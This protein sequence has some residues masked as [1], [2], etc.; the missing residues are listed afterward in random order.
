M[1]LLQVYARYAA[2]VHLLEELLHVGAALVPNPCLGEQAARCP[3]LEDADAEVYVLAEAHGGKTAQAPVEVGTYAHVEGARIELVQ[4]LLA[5]AYASCGEEGGH[6]V[7]DGLLHGRETLVCAVGTSESV[8]WFARKFVVH[9]LQISGGQDA[10]AVQHYEVFALRALGPV[11]ARLAGTAVLLLEITQC[12]PGGVLVDNI[13]ARYRGAVFDHHYLEVLQC[14]H[15]Q[16]G[17]QFVYLVGTIVDGNDEG[18]FHVFKGHFSLPSF[19][20]EPPRRSG[21][22]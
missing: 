3:A 17:K 19:C 13:L 6:G 1:A 15:L 4:F 11:V 10:V 5:S 2:I 21:Q 8:A 9:R 12:Q 7:V 16:A 18:V 22:V 20:P 14:L